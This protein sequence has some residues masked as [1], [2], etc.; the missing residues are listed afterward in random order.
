MTNPPFEWTSIQQSMLMAGIS[1]TVIAVASTGWVWFYRKAVVPAQTF[2]VDVRTGL[3]DVKLLRTDVGRLAA[4]TRAEAERSPS[5]RAEFGAGAVLE[6]ANEQFLRA[7]RLAREEAIGLGWL[8]AFPSSS[9]EAIKDQIIS[10][11]EDK[12][13][14]RI[15][16]VIQT[17]QSNGISAILSMFPLCTGLSDN[18]T[19]FWAYLDVL[20]PKP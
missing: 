19:G 2:F 3:R 10:A 6:F 18:Q 13:V 15:H 17:N 20:E 9:R 5:P 11:G 1:L 4:I 12:R 7:I 14:V 8:Y 16:V